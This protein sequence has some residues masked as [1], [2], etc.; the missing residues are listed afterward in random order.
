MD[1]YFMKN[2]KED[3]S[4]DKQANK[5]ESEKRL[6]NFERQ[7]ESLKNQNIYMQ[8]DRMYGTLQLAAGTKG[9]VSAGVLEPSE[10]RRYSPLRQK[11]Q[12]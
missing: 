3:I 10:A 12:G 1:Q 8:K 5:L 7:L 11:P 2:G 9:R 6:R 4:K